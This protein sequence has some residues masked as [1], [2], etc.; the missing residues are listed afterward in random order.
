MPSVTTPEAVAEVQVREHKQALCQVVSIVHNVNKMEETDVIVQLNSE[1][2]D[3]FEHVAKE[4]VH[5]LVE[6]DHPAKPA[7]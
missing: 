4:A 6:L 1:V 3:S 2:E 7:P 5:T